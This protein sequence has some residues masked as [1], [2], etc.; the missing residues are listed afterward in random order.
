MGKF[1]FPDFK[2]GS[3]LSSVLLFPFMTFT[4]SPVAAVI[5][6][7]FHK[8]LYKDSSLLEL[9][10]DINSPGRTLIQFGNMDSFVLIVNRNFHSAVKELFQCRKMD[11]SVLLLSRDIHNAGKALI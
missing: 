3:S 6:Y 11:R 7:Y 9:N 10:K 1:F 2:N 8:I 5:S 4:I